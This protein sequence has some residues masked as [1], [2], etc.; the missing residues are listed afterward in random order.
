LF[1][2]FADMP[3]PRIKRSPFLE[4]VNWQIEIFYFINPKGK[5]PIEDDFL[6][7]PKEVTRDQKVKL[8]AL[9]RRY[10][11]TSRLKDEQLHRLKGRVRDFWV[12]KSRQHRL[13]FFK[14]G[15]NRIIMTHGFKKQSDKL[16]P[17]EEERMLS[18]RD[19]YNNLSL[20]K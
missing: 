7:D 14:E 12:I 5:C 20:Y 3:R 9:I 16:R 8:V 6:N 2:E 4:G 13:Y 19:I 15:N 17:E 10:A 11:E 1:G 18:Y